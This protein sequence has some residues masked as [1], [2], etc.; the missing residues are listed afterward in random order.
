[1]VDLPDYAKITFPE[2]PPVEFERILPQ[3]E[4]EAVDLA[5]KLLVYDWKRR[6]GVEEALCHE[7]LMCEP[8]PC[9]VEQIRRPKEKKQKSAINVDFD[10]NKPLAQCLIAPWPK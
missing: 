7:Y 1:M 3:A 9:P 8:A 4:S 6:L 2:Y 5:S 10:F